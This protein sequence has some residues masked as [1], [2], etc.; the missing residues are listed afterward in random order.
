M[1][2]FDREADSPAVVHVVDDDEGIRCA[3][4]LAL[5]IAGYAVR[6]HESAPAFLAVIEQDENGCVIT[7]VRMPEMNG[8]ELLA[9]MKERNVSLPA[10]VISAHG[11][12]P[13][14]VAA[15]KLGAV[16]FL[17]KPFENSVIIKL[18]GRALHHH[19]H[20]AAQIAELKSN[21]AR[22]AALTPREHD[23]LAG[24]LQG[25][26]NKV[27]ARELGIGVRSVET[28]R[29]HIMEKMQARNIR[30]LM[31]MTIFLPAPAVAPLDLRTTSAGETLG[32]DVL[33]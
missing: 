33:S 21:E 29:A 25:H 26:Q 6:T 20:Q 27:I 12:I 4:N 18:V 3:L 22:F 11:D 13:L 24:L 30:E 1:E 17:E 8:L 23:V 16:D 5:T 19:R 14:A 31:R 10:L 9:A 32:S 15:M 2:S 7:D 28:H